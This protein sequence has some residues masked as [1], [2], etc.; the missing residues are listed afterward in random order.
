MATPMDRGGSLNYHGDVPSYRPHDIFFVIYGCVRG[1]RNRGEDI[2][3]FDRLI[4][5]TVFIV[6]DTVRSR[7]MRH[8]DMC[9]NR[10]GDRAVGTSL[11]VFI[12]A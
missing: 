3:H 9:P 2:A 12:D 4:S 5:H 8:G 1:A 11:A 7:S 10:S 6:T